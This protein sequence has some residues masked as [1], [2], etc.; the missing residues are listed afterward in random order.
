MEGTGQNRWAHAPSKLT[1]DLS[2]V[3]ANYQTLAKMCSSAEC[4]AVV[5]ANAY[6]LGAAPI[7][8]ALAGA[9]CRTFF[10]ATLDEG[11]ELRQITQ[12]TIYVLNGISCEDASEYRAH[13]LR[14]VLND[15]DQIDIWRRHSDDTPAPPA[16]IHVDTGMNRLGLSQTLLEQIG[17]WEKLYDGL[18]VSL[19]MSHLA[20]ADESYDEKN[21]EQL[22]S[23]HKIIST[24]KDIP[25]SLSAS[26]GIFLGP[27]WHFDLVRPGFALYGGNPQQTAP[28]PL[29]PVVQLSA[30]I[31]QCRAVAKGETVGYG[32][33]YKFNTDKR[34]A[35][36]AVG[37]ADGFFRSLSCCG[38]VFIGKIPLPVLGRV[39]MD[40][41]AVDITGVDGVKAS[42]WVDIIGPHQ[43]VDALA[44]TA[45]TIGYEVLTALGQR[46]HREYVGASA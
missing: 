33:C 24:S 14:P 12:H 45:G 44:A 36:I 7:V 9:G 37:Y 3:V 38:K 28:N 42:D 32:G 25:A 1:I 20:C 2:A 17:K 8:K 22:Q 11:I 15:L 35:T 19:L 18:N 21:F 26:S 41:I 4:A 43:D 31:L 5:K 13:T 27:D 40:L 10:V 23:F 30:K 29:E 16:A 39:S 34:I 6:G 46:H